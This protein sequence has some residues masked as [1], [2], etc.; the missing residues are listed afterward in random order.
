MKQARPCLS[1]LLSMASTSS[2]QVSYNLNWGMYATEDTSG[3]G[4]SLWQIHKKELDHLFY[5]LLL[6]PLSCFAL[7]LL[8]TMTQSLSLSL[9]LSLLTPPVQFSLIK[10]FLKLSF[11]IHKS[12]VTNCSFHHELCLISGLNFWCLELLVIVHI[13][14]WVNFPF[15]FIDAF[16][17]H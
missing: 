6:E 7:I 15:T 5:Y 16:R 17:L 1:A 11:L 10:R 14:C 3:N 12:K 8:Y 4:N 13:N 9:T 2:S